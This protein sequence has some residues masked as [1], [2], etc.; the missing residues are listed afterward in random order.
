[1][2]GNEYK[3][4]RMTDEDMFRCSF[5]LLA[6]ARNL[7]LKDAFVDLIVTSPLTGTAKRQ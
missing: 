2:K 4:Y 7:P 6:D 5:A 1:M 3:L